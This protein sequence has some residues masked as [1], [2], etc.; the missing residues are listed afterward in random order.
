MQ[1]TSGF[2]LDALPTEPWTPAPDEAALVSRRVPA[3]HA[4]RSS[5]TPIATCRTSRRVWRARAALLLPLAPRRRSHRDG[6]DRLQRPGARLA[7]KRRRADG[8]RVPDR[9]RADAS[10]PARRAAAR[11]AA[12]PRR[13]LAEPV[14]D[15]AA[16]A[17]GSTSSATAP[18]GCSARIARRSGFTIGARVSSCCAPRPIP[19]HAVTGVPIAADDPLSPAAVAMRRT[20]AETARGRLRPLRRSRGDVDGHGP[21]ARL[22]PRARH[23]RVRRRAG[24]AGRR[25]GS[26]RPRRRTRPPARPTRSKTCRCST[27]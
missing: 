23:G 10:A 9:D 13:V 14:D 1:A 2:G 8:R 17:R 19:A 27:T 24:R 16:R 3:R 7:R 22:P 11:P 5:P 12:A 4:A 20:R 6:G 25:D 26:A 15:A 18:T 21:A